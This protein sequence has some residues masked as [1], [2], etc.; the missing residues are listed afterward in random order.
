[1]FSQFI[2]LLYGKKELHKKQLDEND[3]KLINHL[4]NYS[5]HRASKHKTPL[6]CRKEDIDKLRIK[7]GIINKSKM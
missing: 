5:W 6:T 4:I 7:L 1:M 3:L 2:N